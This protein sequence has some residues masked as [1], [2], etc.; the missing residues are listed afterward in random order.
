[1][2]DASENDAIRRHVLRQWHTV[3][4]SRVQLCSYSCFGSLLM[5][6]KLINFIGYFNG[7]RTVAPLLYN[8]LTLGSTTKTLTKAQA[9]H[10]AQLCRFTVIYL[11]ATMLS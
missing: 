3:T 4:H 1:M 7:F 2:H 5:L 6:H 8:T 10:T 9:T 11:K